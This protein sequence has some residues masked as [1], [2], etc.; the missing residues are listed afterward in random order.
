M[1]RPTFPLWT[2]R[3]VLRP[4]V[5]KD[6]DALYEIESNE[7]VTR[8]LYWGP[9]SREEARKALQRRKKMIAIDDRSDAL[10]LAA[11]LPDSDT[12]VG[13]F[14]LQ[15][16]SREHN[17]GEIGFI[18]NPAHQGQGYG[19]EGAELLLRL[20]FEELNL[21]RIVGRCD[22]RNLA[23]ARLMERLGMR[24]EAHLRENEFV[25]GEWTDELVYAMLASEWHAR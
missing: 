22:G 18:L 3:L 17:Q 8:Y 7:D 21:H 24:R 13:D 19:T 2:Q 25:K 10:R 5:D 9:R 11:L 14:S 12:L 1:L 23:S 15:R 4:F 6:L 16:T 20:G